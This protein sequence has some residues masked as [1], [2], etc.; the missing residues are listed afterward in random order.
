MTTIR[1]KLGAGGAGGSAGAGTMYHANLLKALEQK[2]KIIE[3]LTKEALRFEEQSLS[4]SLN[5]SMSQSRDG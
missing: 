2:D 5:Q 3:K 1:S 4:Q